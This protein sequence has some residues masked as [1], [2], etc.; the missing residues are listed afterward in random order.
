MQIPIL[1]GVYTDTDADY[2]IAYPVNMRP[3]VQDT[4]LSAGYL[5]PVDG[6]RQ[7][8]TGPGKSRGA[9]NWNNEHYRVMGD[10]LCKI[11]PGGVVSILGTVDDDGGRVSMTYSFDR[12]AIASANKLYYFQNGTLE[13]QTDVD[14]GNVL[15]VIWIDGYFMTTDGTSL[16]VTELDN[17]SAVNPLKY[18]SSEID[19]D[20][21]VA[22]AK[23]RNEV[24]AV[25]R[26]T[27][28]VFD[29]IGTE[30]F[31]FGRIESA[32]IQRGALGTQCVTVYE[33]SIAFLGSG[34]GESPGVY[35]AGGGRT[36]KISTK[37]IDETLL[38]YTE[39]QLSKAVLET[40]NDKSH[41]LLWIRLPD[42]TLCFDLETTSQMGKPAWYVMSSAAPGGF[43]TFRGV[44]VIWCYDTWQVGDTDSGAVGNMDESIA[45]HYGQTVGWEFGT[46]MLYNNGKG[47]IITSLELVALTGRVAFEKD[48][49]IST[50]YSVDGRTWSQDRFIR[51]GKLGDRTKR[52]VWRRQGH[53]RHFRIQRFTGDSDAYLAVSR[54]EAEVEP[55]ST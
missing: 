15:D 34:P 44:D 9:I 17:P 50:S 26:Y 38:N 30:F 14:F 10:K 33:N 8:G 36:Q 16:I 55:L 46:Q 51:I 48:P 22:L 19:P 45:S 11:S 4:G 31:P 37:E 47:G 2:R 41:A 27:I 7:I 49:Q 35:M 18:G 12:L 1:S 21:V 54:L 23:L 20:P 3:V 53:M 52:L 32:Q 42:R 28:E 5:R 40:V 13:E 43:K 25:N 39:E 24:Y 29:N 6:L